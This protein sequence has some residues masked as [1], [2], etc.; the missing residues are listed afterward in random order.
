MSS[1]CAIISMGKRELQCVIVVFPDHP[2][3]FFLFGDLCLYCW[4]IY[5]LKFI[6]AEIKLNFQS[7]IRVH[8]YSQMTMK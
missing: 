7:Y 2:H 8:M 1:I 3:L 6:F 5:D 4:L